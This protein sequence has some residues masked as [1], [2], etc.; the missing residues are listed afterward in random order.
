MDFMGIGFLELLLILVLGVIFIGPDK[1]PE[2]A[3][4]AGQLFRSFRKATFDLT[5]SI[6]EELPAESIKKAFTQEITTET[7]VE[8]TGKSRPSSDSNEEA[9]EQ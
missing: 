7:K 6:T 5:K 2:I 4:K 9:H 1:L 8:N 3:A